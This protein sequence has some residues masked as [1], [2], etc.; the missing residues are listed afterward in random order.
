MT[1]QGSARG[2]CH[3]SATRRG[4][5]EKG[6]MASAKKDQIWTKNIVTMPESH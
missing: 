5:V 4:K 3:G 6:T 1:G 2:Q